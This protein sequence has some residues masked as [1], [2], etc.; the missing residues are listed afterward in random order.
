MSGRLA[1]LGV[2]LLVSLVLGVVAGI[3]WQVAAPTGDVVVGGGLVVAI[4]IPELEAAQDATF[5]VVTAAAGLVSGAWLTAV[6]GTVPLMRAAGVVVGGLLGS[7]V[8]WGVGAQLGPPSIAAQ[9]AA[10]VEPLQS[11]L[12]LSSYGA[13]GVW[14]AVAA[15]VA[16]AGL[17]VTGL[18]DVRS[19]R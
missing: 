3:V 18:L 4:G 13:L 5:V 8:A 16:F 14:S 6:P 19:R 2:P 1:A 10:G 15:A 9:E 7:L 12:A 11:P 17:L